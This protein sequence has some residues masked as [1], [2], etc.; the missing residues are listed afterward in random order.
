MKKWFF[1][2]T[3][4]CICCSLWSQ[5]P[6]GYYASTNGQNGSNLKTALHYII[7]D[8][9]ERDYKKDLWTD[10]QTT[11]VRE[12]GQVWDMYSSTTNYTFVEEQCGNYKKEGDCYNREHSFPKDW[13]D[14]ATPMYS[15]L[16]HLYPTDGYVN[17]QRSNLPFGETDSPTYTSQNGHSRKGPSSISGYSG[18]VFEPA[19]EYKGDMARTYFYMATC[20]EDRIASWHCDMLAGNSYPCYREWAIDMLLRWAAEDPVSEKEVKRNNAVYGIQGNRNPFI[21]FPG[22]EQYVWGDKINAAFNPND[23]NGGELPPVEDVE[24]PTFTPESGMVSGETVITINVTNPEAYIVYSINNGT[25]RT[26][27]APVYVP[28]HEETTIEAYA[29]VGTRTSTTVSATYTLIQTQPEE[30]IQTFRKV[31]VA[32][33]LQIGRKYLVVCE[34]NNVAL[35]AVNKDVRSYSGI[36]IQNNEIKTETGREGLPYQLALGGSAGAYTLYDAASQVYL[37]VTSDGNK[38]HSISASESD[39]SLW[40]ISISD[41]I[42]QILNKAYPLR[43]IRYNASSPRFAC[44]KNTQQV[45]SLYVN[46][47]GETD[48]RAIEDIPNDKVDVYTIGGK[49][50]RK[51]VA[52]NKALNGLKQGIYIIKGQTILVK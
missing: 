22:L 19:D 50:V 24:A 49:L 3:L 17:G 23:Y 27:E 28:I 45:V 47:T 9:I 46:I 12:D 34:S 38:L 8:H 33:D 6:E 13:F 2:A 18:E 44:Y 21:D 29:M 7:V 42:A 26:E 39:E 25:L 4:L 43:S 41:G 10:M 5:I 51:N 52:T 35:G 31:T 11:D 1:S 30:G 48:I 14:D 16:F 15:D 20:Y 40:N 32:E 37:A 36:T